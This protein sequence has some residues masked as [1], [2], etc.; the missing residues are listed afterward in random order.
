MSRTTAVRPLLAVLAALCL[1]AGCSSDDGGGSA[2]AS[3]R[4]T[5][6]T[7]T[8]TPRV[9]RPEGPEADLSEELVEGGGIIL[10]SLDLTDL[11]AAGYVEAEHVATGTATSY[12]ADE[13]P[14]DGT[15][16]LTERDQAPYRTRV[17]VRRPAEAADF[18][19]TVVLEWLNVSGGI[20]AN[21]DY[22][23]MA[24]E[25]LRG[26]YA[27]VGVSAQHIGI[28]GGPVAVSMPLADAFMGKG[29][30]AI[31]PA[32][33]GSLEH[34]GD[35]YAYDIYTQVA[36]ALRGASADVVLGEL[37]PERILAVGESQSGFALTTYANGVQPLTRQFDGF[38]IH[39]R[40]GAAAPL[41][42]PGEGIDITGTVGGEPTIVRTD[43][44]VP[45]LILQSESDVVGTLGYLPARQD[46]TELLRLW[47]IAGTAHADRHL[48]GPIADEVDCGPEI[49]DG[50]HHF[51]AKA[52]LRSL[53]RWVRDGT[54]PATAPRL[55]VDDDGTYVRD[56]DGI[57]EGGIRMPQVDVPVDV[58]SGDPGSLENS[59]ACILLGTTVPLDPARIVELHGGPEEY[60]AAYEAAAEEAI[61]SGFVLAEDRDALLADA[62]PSRFAD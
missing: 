47:E 22:S 61:E 24:E 43:L 31:D 58:L 59:V 33:Y 29:L 20:D 45:V 7:S 30:R 1:A 57:V 6:T 52:A 4:S 23:Y 11:E 53:D 3:D 51:V 50:P 62:D 42:E 18:N 27:W 17:V 26:G 55:E 38:L 35:A 56:A 16:E 2:D 8:T 40:G 54:A 12:Q 21:P 10:G 32:R 9:E 46:D 36:R 13:L 48:L 15:F 41:G 44:E 5:S 39:S 28:E 14:T 60:L 19:G 49:N 25:L 34:P 37:E